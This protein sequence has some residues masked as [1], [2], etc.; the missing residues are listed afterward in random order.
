[1]ENQN[2]IQSH[3]TMLEALLVNEFRTCQSLQTIVTDERS[4]LID[5][6]VSRLSDLVEEKECVLDKLGQ[7]EDQRRMM[8]QELSRAFGE[9]LEKP[10]VFGLLPRLDSASAGRLGRLCDGITTIISNIRQYND[11]NQAL[12]ESGLERIDA[13][14][15]F[16]LSLIQVPPNYQPP[17]TH[18]IP[19]R[20]VIYDIDQR[21]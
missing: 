4:A 2:S 13:V 12:A 7:I 9:R 3:L 15:S 11:G 18:P 6:D 10:S 14:Q 8:V 20:A 17:G 21:A 5:G 1:M 16:I 19:E